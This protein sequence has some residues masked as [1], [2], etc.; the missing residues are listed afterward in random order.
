MN[1][2]HKHELSNVQIS[3]WD[4]FQ[5]M[6]C[7]GNVTSD[8]SSRVLNKDDINIK[9]DKDNINQKLG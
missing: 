7:T 6:Q 9:I 4:Y 5:D 1:N 8:T 3:K 2:D